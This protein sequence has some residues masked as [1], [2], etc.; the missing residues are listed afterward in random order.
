MNL[1]ELHTSPEELF[2]YDEQ[3]KMPGRVWPL[4]VN[5]LKDKD[6]ADQE[7]LW[8]W[9]VKDPESA[10]LYAVW[11]G[12]EFPEGEAAIIQSPQFA[13]KY[14]TN[15]R[16]RKWP[17]AEDTILDNTVEWQIYATEFMGKS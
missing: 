11:K 1:Y 10:Y 16:M 17:E 7:F 13:R 6:T 2:G 9:L 3:Y 15:V 4:W 12:S 5:S 14:A 8:P